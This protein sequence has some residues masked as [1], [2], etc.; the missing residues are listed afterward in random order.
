MSEPV[1][2]MPGA[3]YRGLVKV[4]EG[5]L[6]GMVTLRAD[7][8]APKVAEAV[9]AAT[10]APMPGVLGL[11]RGEGGQ[12]A[13][14]SPDELLLLVE[15]ERAGAVAADL[16]QRLAGLH[17]LALDVSDAR[18]VF[19]LEGAHVRE[20]L[21]K[22]T[23]ADVFALEPGTVRRSRLAQVPGAFWLESEH[24]AE[25]LCFRSVAHYVFEL[26]STAAQPGSAVL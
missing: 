9:R 12:V 2:V 5:G 10:M 1:S 14:M 3:L 13:W 6:R 7:L 22:L 23:P 20:V 24:E 25:V 16:S 8:A 18:A 21:A 15:H 26:L 19:T 17:A 11:S 4:A